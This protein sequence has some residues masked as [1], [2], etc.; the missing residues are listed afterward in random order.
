M[1]TTPRELHLTRKRMWEASIANHA[2]YLDPSTGKF[3]EKY[4]EERICPAC[5]GAQSAYLL[6]KSGGTYVVCSGCEMVFTNPAFKDSVLIEYYTANHSVQSEIV[7]SDQPFYRNLYETGLRHISANSSPAE[8]SARNILDVGCSSGSFLNIAREQGWKTFGLELNSAEI[9]AAIGAG[10]HVLQTTIDQASFAE[11]FEA[12]TLWDVFEHIKDGFSFLSSTRR[13]LAPGGIVFIQSPS[14]D[15][16]AARI[17][18]EHCNMFDGLEHVNLYGERQLSVLAERAGFKV[19]HFSSVISEV[20][21][22]NNF[23]SY[24]DPYLG[25]GTETKTLLGFLDSDDILRR[26][27][28]YKFQA[29]LVSK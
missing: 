25:A 13:L 7:A 5:N 10:H 29:C 26:K 20:G 19:A 3:Q 2:R 8:T 27:L 18:R 23:L 1:S 11:R 24:D 6:S 14:R 16:L 22:M 4:L 21:V 9:K 15:A 12:I 17:M 28:G